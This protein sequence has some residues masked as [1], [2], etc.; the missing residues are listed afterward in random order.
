MRAEPGDLVRLFR[1]QPGY[2]RLLA[3]R[4]TS[5]FG[6]GAFNVGLAGLFFFSPQRATTPDAVAWAMTAGLLPYTLVSPFAGVLLDRWYRRQVM[7]IANVIR[8]GLVMLAASLVAGGAPIGWLLVVA[9]ICLGVDRFVLA[10]VQAALPHVVERRLLVLA[11][12]LTP[13]LGTVSMLA[14]MA[15]GFV[16]VQAL[17]GG[18]RAGAVALLLGA[19][20]Y[21]AAGL[22][23][24]TLGRTALGPDR[25]LVPIPL[26]HALGHIA[27]GMAHGARHVASRE[28]GRWAFALI[29]TTRVGFGT[30]T[31][32][33]IL[34]SRNTFTDDVQ[35]GLDLVAVI[36]GLAGLGTAAAS[37]LTPLGLRAMRPRWWVLLCLGTIAAIY[38]CWALALSRSLFVVLALPLGL[39]LQGL[40]IVIDTTLQLSLDEPYWGRVFS[41]ADVAY[42][43][44]L[45]LAALL[46]VVFVPVTG[47]PPALLAALAGLHLLVAA[48][49]MARRTAPLQQA[50]LRS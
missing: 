46:A 10:G 49:T 22:M 30:F 2:L 15:G 17:G 48:W 4:V 21:A 18:D 36:V 16:L 5:Q 20:G 13:T 34:L 3:V 44:G 40:K 38:L 12:S 6:D 11:N 33:T 37:V 42:N 19:A 29:G 25:E 47:Q 43:S 8:V 14:G 27:A 26:A 31:V 24:L 7:L 35:A 50:G 23:T 41:L 9:L 39:A 32:M 28:P 45:I 1:H